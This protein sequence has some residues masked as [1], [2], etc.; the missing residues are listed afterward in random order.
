MNTLHSGSGESVGKYTK[1]GLGVA[2]VLL[3][4]VA[5]AILPGEWAM[6]SDRLILGQVHSEPLDEAE[7]SDYVNISMVDKV[8]LLGQTSGTFLVSLKT[9]AVY[10]PDTVGNKF[11]EELKRLHDL[12]FFPLPGSGKPETMRSAATLYIQNDAPAINTIVWEISMRLDPIAGVFYMDDQTGKIL[13]FTLSGTGSGDWS[14]QE[15]MAGRWASYLG[16]EVRNVKKDKQTNEAEEESDEVLYHFELISGA[17]S[18]SGQ[19][20]SSIETG[21][22]GICR[23]C[24]QYAQIRQDQVILAE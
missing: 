23:W 14:Y 15:D 13:S 5:G 10:D 7:L 9:G 24:L 1:Y 4:I 16:A 6:R 18:V 20:S 8:S 22:G 3:L 11:T 21:P 12:G 2:A 19:L 17:R